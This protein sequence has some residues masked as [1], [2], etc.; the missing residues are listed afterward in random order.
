MLNGET[1][2]KT[3][4]IVVSLAVLLAVLNVA[5]LKGL[6]LKRRSSWWYG[7]ISFICGISVI[8][9]LNGNLNDGQIAGIICAFL[10]MLGGATTRWHK[11]EFEGKFRSLV[12]EYGKEDDPSLFA[13]LVRKLFGKY[14]N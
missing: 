10:T 7:V 4:L 3:G 13:K 5:S 14:K 1:K 8:M 6:D 9:V 12:I 2:L 11:Q